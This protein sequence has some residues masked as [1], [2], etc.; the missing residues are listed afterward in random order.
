MGF[1]DTIKGWFNLGGVKVKLLCDQPQ[2]S[3][4]GGEISGKASL[5]SKSDK[6]VLKMHHKLIMEVT[7]GSKDDKKTKETLLGELEQSEQFEMK[8]GESKDVDFTVPYEIP[9]RLADKGG[10]MGAVGKL[11]AFTSSEKIAYY[12]V[13]ECDVKGTAF[14]P[15]DRVKVTLAG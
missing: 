2:I 3:K 13:S 4:P 15:S 6:T 11:G 8:A 14:D 12:L 10:M 7:T 9:E 1:L 5:T